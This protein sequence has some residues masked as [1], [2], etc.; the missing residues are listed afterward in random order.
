M[1]PCMPEVSINLGENG[2]APHSFGSHFVREALGVS[3]KCGFRGGIGKRGVVERQP[4]LD[5]VDVD[6]SARNASGH[7][8]NECP[9]QADCRHQVHVDRTASILVR[10]RRKAAVRRFRSAYAVDEDVDASHSWFT[11]SVMARIPS[12]VPI[13]AW[14]NTAGRWVGT[15]AGVPSPNSLRMTCKRSSQRG[16]VRSSQT[17]TQAPASLIRLLRVP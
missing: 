14:M 11:L 15:Q 4:T 17:K 10:K 6:H 13:S 8:G 3:V 2:V 9:A 16:S 7:P 1:M 5:G 12:A